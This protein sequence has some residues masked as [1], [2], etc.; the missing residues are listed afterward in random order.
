M[1]CAARPFIAA[2]AAVGIAQLPTHEEQKK[3]RMG[4]RKIDEIQLKT[5]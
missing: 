2:G 3:Q 1:V 5:P 4:G